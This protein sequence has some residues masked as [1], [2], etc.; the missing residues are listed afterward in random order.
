[1]STSAPATVLF[2]LDGTLLDTA[3]DMVAVL[4]QVQA[5]ENRAPLPY[6]Q[7]RCHVSHGVTGLL[8]IAFGELAE[9]ERER[10]RLRYLENYAARLVVETA[11]F[12]GMQQVLARLE[13]LG[14]PWGI[15]TNKPASL[16]EPLLERLGLRPRCACV[17][18]GDTTARRKPHPEPLLHALSLIAA[19]PGAAYYVGDAER[20]I[21][22][23]R[24]AGMRTVA[25]LYGYIPPEEDPS[26]WGAD[27]RVDSPAG[28]LAILP[29]PHAARASSSQAST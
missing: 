12:A 25:A 21:V 1:M 10:L 13:D 26:A 4:H 16:T 9:Q 28:L 11:L 3:P 20:D 19:A 23:G 6:A 2:D 5:E 22:A 8:R 15:V 7:A 27:H 17:V 18:S 24:A 29:A 14:I